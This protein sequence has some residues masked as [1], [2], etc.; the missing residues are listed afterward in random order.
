MFFYILTINR[1]LA[2]KKKNLAS[3]NDFLR[4]IIKSRIMNVFVLIARK[5][6]MIMVLLAKRITMPLFAQIITL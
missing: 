2:K 3:L 1:T 6:N 4:N 5:S